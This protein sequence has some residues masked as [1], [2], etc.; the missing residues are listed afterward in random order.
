MET[1]IPLLTLVAVST[2]ITAIIVLWLQHPYGACL[3]MGI[4]NACLWVVFTFLGPVAQSEN[5][6][7]NNDTK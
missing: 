6:N 2:T 1:T 5:Q 4:A 3:F 7:K